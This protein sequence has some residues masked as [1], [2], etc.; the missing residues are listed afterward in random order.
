MNSISSICRIPNEIDHHGKAIGGEIATMADIVDQNG[1]NIQLE[2][3]KIRVSFEKEMQDMAKKTRNTV[4]A[5][6]AINI[7]TR[8]LIK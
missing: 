6:V 3:E 2:L 1:K 7:A 5:V 8:L 4:I